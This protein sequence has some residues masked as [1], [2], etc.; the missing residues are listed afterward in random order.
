M[1]KF[2]KNEFLNTL[3]KILLKKIKNNMDYKIKL[4]K[5]ELNSDAES[6]NDQKKTVLTIL[7]ESDVN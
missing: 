6:Y 3:V 7:Q 4:N 1:L 2:N 5:S